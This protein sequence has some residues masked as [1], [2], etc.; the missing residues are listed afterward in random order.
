MICPDCGEEITKLITKGEHK[1]ICKRC[2]KRIQ[3][4]EYLNKKNGTNKE[5]IPII[6]L[7]E[8]DP[9]TYNRI[10]GRRSIT[11][12]SKPKKVST[13]K[14]KEV[15]KH[16]DNIKIIYYGKVSNDLD[17]A[18][19]D[20]NIN[21]DYT[22]YSNLPLW[23]DTFVSLLSDKDEDNFIIQCK[24]G[25][26]IFNRL[27]AIYSHEKENLDW[28]DIEHINEISFA[29]KALCELRRPTKELLDYYYCIDAV[30]EHLKEDTKLMD[31]ILEAKERLEEKK[32]HHK[33]PIFFSSVGSSMVSAVNLAKSVKD[34]KNK[35][36]DCTVWCYNLN[37]NPRKSLFRANNGILARNEVDAK[38]K[39]KQFLSEKFSSVV[40]NDRDIM[41]KEVNSRKEIDELTRKECP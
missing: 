16:N 3:Q 17:K 37:G 21:T 6:K 28:D 7:K 4:N 23:I 24:K 27:G 18:F 19:K 38:L 10:M 11:D 35:I 40:Y 36:Y 30:I 8:K 39:L 29:E 26:D 22:K 15:I 1:G 14:E 2:Y 5:Y 13:S 34:S 33:N 20:A 12:K 25:E 41:I 31:L 9:I 32:E